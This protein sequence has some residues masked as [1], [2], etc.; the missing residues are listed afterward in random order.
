[1]SD[2]ITDQMRSERLERLDLESWKFTDAKA[3]LSSLMQR[4]LEGRPQR[5]VRGG[6]ESVVVISEAQYRETAAP[7]RN[8][9][10]LFSALRG[11][12]IELERDRDFGRETTL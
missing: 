4:A 1:M 12:G 2:Y 11:S 6:R 9:V 7:R 8:L 10:D 3:K 5:I